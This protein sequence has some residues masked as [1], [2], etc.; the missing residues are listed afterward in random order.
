MNKRIDQIDIVM[1][2]IT[3]KEK[4][5]FCGI[6]FSY[7]SLI[8]IVNDLLNYLNLYDLFNSS[9]YESLFKTLYL[10]KSK[11]SYD[12]IADLYNIH[13]YTLDRYRQKFNSF[14]IKLLK[15]IKEKK[16]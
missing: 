10:N 15:T 9:N 5:F 4:L 7:E 16:Q 8:E 3:N 12:S 13:P 14:L 11:L 1:K 6:L 2:H